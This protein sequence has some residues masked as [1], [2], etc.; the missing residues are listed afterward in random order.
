MPDGLNFNMPRPRFAY[1][2]LAR[3]ADI[4]LAEGDEDRCIELIERLYEL[5]DGELAA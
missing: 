5:L 4:A 1:Q 3:E 2:A